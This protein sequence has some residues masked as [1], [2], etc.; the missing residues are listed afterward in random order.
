MFDFITNLFSNR[1]RYKTHSEAV[2]VSCFY[3]PQNSQY[4][5]LAFQKWYSSIKHLNYRIIECLIGPDAKS[6]LPLDDPNIIRIKSD[7]LL[8]H[9]ESLLNKAIESLPS[10]FQYVFWVDADVLFTNKN[11]LVEG[12]KRMKKGANIIQPFEYC[13]HLKQNEIEPSINVNWAKTHLNPKEFSVWRSFCATF[14]QNKDL[15]L[16]ENYDSHGHVG[17]AWG[18][19]RSVLEKCPLY[20]RALIGGAD[21]IIAHAATGYIHHPCVVKGFKDNIDE[22]D[23]WSRDFY[24]EVDAQIDYVPGDLHHIWHGDIAKRQYLKRVK[25]FTG[26]VKNIRERDENGL[27]VA[28]KGK[29]KYVKSYY[30]DREVSDYYGDFDGVDA[31]FFMTM[32]YMLGEAANLFGPP[33]I[34][35]E[36]PPEE[37]PPEQLPE[38]PVLEFQE[39]L[40]IQDSTSQEVDSE[41]YS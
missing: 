19:K 25:D 6:Q 18:A 21:H 26:E 39:S 29:D 5:L 8:W 27:H 12:V 41:T 11:W 17:F 35:E 32:G 7:S 40:E 33:Q 24:L 3:N 4:R 34:Y 9:K 38:E 31:D 1:N 36:L 22:I 20:D 10:K 2:I 16:G 14:V 30:R 28:Q 37:L 15:A 13:V 23:K